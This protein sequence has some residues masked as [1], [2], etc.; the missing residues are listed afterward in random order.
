MSTVYAL[1]TTMV[2][3]LRSDYEQSIADEDELDVN[4][5]ASEYQRGW[6][7]GFTHG[8]G[9]AISIAEDFLGRFMKG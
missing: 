8:I 4:R 6:A 2:Q 3:R 7:S 9:H 5:S 1:I